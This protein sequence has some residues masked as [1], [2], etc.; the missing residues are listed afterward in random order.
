MVVETPPGANIDYLRQKV[1]E[2][3]RL[4]A[5]HP[6]V[7]Y[8][9]VTGGGA[10]GAVDKASVFVKLSTKGERLAAGQLGA[11][12][13]AAAFREDMKGI[14]GAS[15]SVFTSDF[16]GQQKQISLE[17]RGNNKAAL[18]VVARAQIR[19]GYAILWALVEAVLRQ[20]A[21]VHLDQIGRASC[22]ERV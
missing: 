22:R 4:A 16:A 1:N 8:T 6:E 11:E 5:K 10:S 18:Q 9:F 21:L 20:A 12:D 3:I 17:L 14:G 7:T 19:V 15:V 13:L 2:A